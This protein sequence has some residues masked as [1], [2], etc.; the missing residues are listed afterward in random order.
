MLFDM[1]GVRRVKS[2]ICHNSSLATN[3][4][5]S[6]SID[7]SVYLHVNLDFCWRQSIT[8]PN[9]LTCSNFCL[10]LRLF[11]VPKAMFCQHIENFRIAP[12]TIYPL[13]SIVLSSQQQKNPSPRKVVLD[14]HRMLWNPYW[15][16]TV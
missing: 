9:Y 14:F 8:T 7:L 13:L 6:F 2:P 1:T 15:E 12:C 5:R 4:R 10:S 11:K 16:R 3:K